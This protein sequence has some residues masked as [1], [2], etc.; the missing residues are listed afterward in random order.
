MMLHKRGFFYLIVL[1]ALAIVF[2][3]YYQFDQIKFGQELLISTDQSIVQPRLIQGTL[4]FILRSISIV[5]PILPGTYCSVLSGFLF[6]VK[7][8]LVLIFFADFFSC[9]SSFF[10]SRKFGRDFVAKLL[11]KTQI[12]KIENLSQRYL[13]KNLFLM[14]SF[15][16]TNFFDFVC[17]AM[18][19]TKLK[20]IK[21]MP[22]LIISILISDAPF[23]AGGY[24]LR[25]VKEI[26]I[27]KIINGDIQ[28]LQ[29]PYL[30]VF[31]ISV[32]TIFILAFI[33]NRIIK[34]SDKSNQN[35]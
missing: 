29:G 1:G 22:A 19:L 13:E 23:V 18:G 32:T 2:L 5:F 16:L 3:Y 15:L 9:T 7:P 27:K 20:W 4:I 21:F 34:N 10:I 6:G 11:G 33:N 12:K 28:V 8:G 17:Y 14:T 25:G 30:S 24:A 31:I 35:L 26:S